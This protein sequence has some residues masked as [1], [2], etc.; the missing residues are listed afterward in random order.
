MKKP[1]E[2]SRGFLVGA[3]DVRA[4]TTRS[5]RDG[6]SISALALSSELPP[7]NVES[8]TGIVE[9]EEVFSARS[10]G[11]FALYDSSHS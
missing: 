11:V 3:V 7:L 8:E 10:S 2:V 1:Q 5:P 6:S 9:N 4:S